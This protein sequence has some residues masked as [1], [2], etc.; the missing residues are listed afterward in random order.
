LL[1]ELRRLREIQVEQAEALAAADLERLTVLDGERLR[2][3][4]RIAPGDTPALSPADAAE[5]RALVDL[6]QRDQRELMERA[7]A[8]RDALRAELG[9][10]RSG[11]AALAGYRPAAGGS[12]LYLD[13]AR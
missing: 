2:V 10:L 12:S 9:S 13:S 5:A 3:Q 1:A 7:A 11:R 6:L 4:A 8:A